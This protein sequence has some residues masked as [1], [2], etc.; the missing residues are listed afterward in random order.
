MDKEIE[1]KETMSKIKLTTK[2]KILSKK[3][4]KSSVE[5]IV[6]R[7]DSLDGKFL[8]VKVGNDAHPASCQDIKD[9]ENKLIGLLEENNVNCLVFVTHHAV[10]IEIIEK[11]K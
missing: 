5:V 6:R 10:E 11:L 4:T 3:G 8:L 1:S 2:K 9:I 7:F